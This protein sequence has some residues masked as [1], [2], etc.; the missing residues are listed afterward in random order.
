MSIYLKQL[1]FK[2]KRT[3]GFNNRVIILESQHMNTESYWRV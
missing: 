2:W 1:Y 3:H